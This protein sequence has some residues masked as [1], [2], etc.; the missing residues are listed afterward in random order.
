MY[1]CIKK[2]YNKLCIFIFNV[3]HKSV[4]SFFE[5]QINFTTLLYHYHRSHTI[6][7][8]NFSYF[9]RIH[10]RKKQMLSQKQ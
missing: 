9:N 2:K 10:D 3:Y 6:P 7:L 1:H 5:N 8:S 4:V